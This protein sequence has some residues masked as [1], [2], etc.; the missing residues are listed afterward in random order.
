MLLRGRIRL[1][2]VQLQR[3]QGEEETFLGTTDSSIGQL[4]C[5]QPLHTRNSHTSAM[6]VDSRLPFDSI[7][8]IRRG[9]GAWPLR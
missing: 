3:E 4:H 9:Q 2:R 5:T 7:S 8:E 6:N 1:Q